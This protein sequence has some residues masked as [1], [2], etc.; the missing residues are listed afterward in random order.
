MRLTEL[1]DTTLQ[2]FQ[3]QMPNVPGYVIQDFIYKNYKDNPK[4][5][6]EAITWA[7]Q[8]QW[9][10][11]MLNVTMAGWDLET[12]RRIKERAGGSKNPFSIPNDE[13]RHAKQ[14]QL[15]SQGPSKEPI[16]AAVKD[17]KYEL[18]EGW[19]RTIQSMATWP[20]GYKQT[21]WVGRRA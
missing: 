17:G 20:N 21:A 5:A 8:F 2:Y 4:E 3:Q 9:K 10:Q 15:L 18:I 14:Q 7:N 19:H 1:R 16:I 6:N 12:Q 13:E 11:Q